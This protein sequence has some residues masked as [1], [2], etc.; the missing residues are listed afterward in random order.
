MP[1]EDPLLTEDHRL[2]KIAQRHARKP[3]ET[4]GPGLPDLFWRV[5]EAELVFELGKDW[6]QLLPKT[7][8]YCAP[9]VDIP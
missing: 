2:F 4:R 9:V 8:T 6:R 3:I 5:V 1:T 7:T